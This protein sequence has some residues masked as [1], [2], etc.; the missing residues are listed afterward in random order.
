MWKTSTARRTEE[1]LYIDQHILPDNKTR[2]A[3]V[4]IECKKAKYHAK[5]GI[6]TNSRRKKL[7]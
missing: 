3:M 1:L 2:G 5:Q 4:W 7:N 6:G